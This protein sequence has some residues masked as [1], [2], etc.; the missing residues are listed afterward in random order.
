MS[1]RRKRGILESVSEPIAD[2]KN[3]HSNHVSNGLGTSRSAR[4]LDRCPICDYDFATLPDAYR[5]PECGFEYDEH[6]RVWMPGRTYRLG[7]LARLSSWFLLL[8]LGI[9][10]LIAYRQNLNK[11]VL[12]AVWLILGLCGTVPRILLS[13]R[14]PLIVVG[15]TGILLQSGGRHGEVRKDWSFLRAANLAWLDDDWFVPVSCSRALTLIRV[16]KRLKMSLADRSEIRRA[17]EEGLKRY[18]TKES[19]DRASEELV[20]QASQSE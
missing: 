10:W 7:R 11:L 1:T 20:E 17:L 6:T 4:G 15:P 13:R 12:G 2:G 3:D 16:M 5:C 19:A 18:H 8:V 9:I 14:K